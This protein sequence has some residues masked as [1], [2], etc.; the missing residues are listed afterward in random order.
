M[1]SNL[2]KPAYSIAEL[3]DLLGIGH[4]SAYALVRS[5]QIPSVRVGRRHV[6]PAAS[7]RAFLARAEV[8]P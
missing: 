5:G 6:I 2:S 4:T 1:D 3:P 8:T 7:I